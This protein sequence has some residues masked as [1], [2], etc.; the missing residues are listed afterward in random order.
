MSRSPEKDEINVPI[1]LS[2]KPKSNARAGVLL[3]KKLLSLLLLLLLYYI[4]RRIYLKLSKSTQRSA[5]LKAL[6]PAANGQIITPLFTFTVQKY[7]YPPVS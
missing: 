7:I 4:D 5:G 3:K 1:A 6:T 2:A